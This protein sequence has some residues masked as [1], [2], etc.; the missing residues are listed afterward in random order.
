MINQKHTIADILRS[1]EYSLDIFSQEEIEKIKLFDKNGKPYLYDFVNGKERQGLPEEIV[2]QLFLYR[3]MNT[4]HYPPQRITVEK[5][6]YFGS[7]VA[8]K[9]A[10][11]VVSDK[12]YPDTVYIIVE[13]KKP[14]RQDGLEQLKS[15]CNA[16]GAPIAVWTNGNQIEIWHREDPNIYRKITDL[17]R[18]T[19][20]LTQIIQD[21]GG[22]STR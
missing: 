20:T 3:L 8:E 17:P 1:T 7:S 19:Q 13:V 21:I 10:D 18:A 12:D 6:V 22:F 11:I 16:E 4:Y 2:R 15:Y 5:G 9:R 14:K